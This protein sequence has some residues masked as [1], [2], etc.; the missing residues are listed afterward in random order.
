MKKSIFFIFTILLVFTFFRSSFSQDKIV[1]LEQFTGAWCGWCVDGTYIMDQILEKYPDNVIGVKIHSGDSMEIEE[2]PPMNTALKVPGFPSGAID[3]KSWGGSYAVYRNTWMQNVET[4][5]QSTPRVGVQLAYAINRESRQ[6]QA[7]VYC[8]MLKDVSNT[9]KFN[10]YI[11]EDSVSGEGK[12]WDQSNYLSNKAGYEDN[13]YYHLPNP[14]IGY[15]HM[16]VVRKMLGGPFGMGDVPKPAKSGEVYTYDFSYD[17]P[18]EWDIDQLHFIGLVQIDESNNFE[19]LNCAYGVEGEPEMQLTSTGESF[20]VVPQGVPFDKVYNL[21]NISSS[22]KTFEL[23]LKNSDRTPSDWTGQVIIN[24]ELTTVAGNET[25]TVSVTLDPGADADI[26]LQIVPGQTLGVGD[27]DIEL[28]SVDNP[29]GFRSKGVISC[30]SQEL[31]NLEVINAG[32]SKYSIQSQ[33]NNTNWD[34]FFSLNSSDYNQFREKFILK[35]HI[36]WNTGAADRFTQ[37]DVNSILADIEAGRKVFVCGNL[38]ASYLSTYGGLP[39]F[40]AEP[41]GFSTQ[42]YGSSPWRVWFSG[43]AGDPISLNFGT[44]TEGNLIQYLINLM[45]I[46]D[47]ENT[48]PFLHF[49]YDGKKVQTIGSTRDTADISG[50]D[51]VFGVRVRHENTRS[52]LLGINPYVIVN[53][54]IRQEL[55][56]RIIQWLNN[57]GPELDLN[58]ELLDFGYILLDEDKLIPVVMHNPGDENLIVSE[59]SIDGMDAYAFTIE[60]QNQLPITIEPGKYKNF[61]VKFKPIAEQ[62]YKANLN[63]KSDAGMNPEVVLDIVASGGTTGI[64]ERSKN[65]IFTVMPNPASDKLRI[66]TGNELSLFDNCSISVYNLHGIQ[67]LSSKIENTYEKT[68]DISELNPGNYYIVLNISG[69][70]YFEP[71]IIVR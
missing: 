53:A 54:D 24:K 1:L 51:A 31:E 39:T 8:T 18:L 63:I 28:S 19:I 9:L 43:V 56:S 23:A 44:K 46:T 30:Y 50:K 36:V 12:G 68:I 69:K 58:Q 47:T 16:K 11:L 41:I 40:G 5:I 7:K 26:T 62:S 65:S 35:N 48:K 33:L 61:M 49:T 67:L 17:I 38:S 27:V 59:I 14:I 21:K 52:V 4:A 15:Q 66:I 70:R 3:R 37:D 20:D 2:Y 25:K 32:E 22:E 57:T 42:G 60:N 71:L 13:P 64:F 34:G 10:V 55:I 45:K 6:L 29:E